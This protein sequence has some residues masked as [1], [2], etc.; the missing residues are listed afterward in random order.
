MAALAAISRY[1]SA[2]IDAETRHS[3]TVSDGETRDRIDADTYVRTHGDLFA[4]KYAAP[5]FDK[6]AAQWMTVGFID[7]DAAWRRFQ[8]LL[9]EKAG[10]FSGLC[11]EADTQE[12][13]FTKALLYRKAGNFAIQEGVAEMLAFAFLLN[14]SEALFF[15]DVQ[16]SLAAL[17]AKTT[18]ALT[19]CTVYVECDGDFE[20]RVGAALTAAFG[21]Q[22]FPVVREKDAAIYQCAAKVDGNGQTLEAGTFYRPV[23]TVSVAGK[24]GAVFTWGT[25]LAKVGAS[26]P[27]VAKGRAFSALVKEIQS[28]LLKEKL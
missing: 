19:F 3:V 1:F 2:H 21:G 22:G 23:V 17:P 6:G 25:T 20:G 5:W 27:N 8:P 15:E 7:R 28:S 12:D 24:N 4:V 10:G 14:P 16:G 18:R 9:E 13:A 26:D 11:L